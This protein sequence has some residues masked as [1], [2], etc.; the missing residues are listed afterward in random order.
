MIN[1]NKSRII[2]KGK[3][4]Q[5]PDFYFPVKTGIYTGFFGGKD[6]WWAGRG[7]KRK[8]PL[9]SGGFWWAGPGLA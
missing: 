8:P 3:S 5:N 9:W 1:I 4:G 6:F 2:C 7:L